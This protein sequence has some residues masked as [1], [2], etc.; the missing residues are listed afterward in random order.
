MA[1]ELIVAY[2]TYDNIIVNGYINR[3]KIFFG[4]GMYNTI[5]MLFCVCIPAWF[6]LAITSRY[7][8]IYTV[9]GLGNIIIVFFTMS[10]QNMLGAAI[11]GIACIIWLL[12]E[13]KGK[14]R[15]INLLIIIAAIIIIGIFIGVNLDTINYYLKGMIDN[16]TED[17]GN[18]VALWQR[19]WEDFLKAPVFGVG[20]YYLKDLDAG[21]VGLDII[22]KMYHNT[23]LQM[24][25]AC[26]VVGIV[27]YLFHRAQTIMSFL[28]KINQER[29]YLAVTICGLL[30]VSLFDNHMFYIFP[31]IIY[32]GLIGILK[33]SENKD[34]QVT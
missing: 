14:E 4:W 31:T 16:I 2:L 17:G 1:I 5:G 27:A 33:S 25:G 6:Y 8:F 28:K 20:F 7:S 21:F 32:V 3:S 13:R 10:R 15:L 18:R 34:E 9:F 12:I 24:L 11:I 26:G 30:F 22:P 23:G 29:I 19:A